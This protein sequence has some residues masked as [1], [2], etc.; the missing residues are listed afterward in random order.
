[1]KALNRNQYFL[2]IFRC[3][4]LR[5]VILCLLAALA[6]SGCMRRSAPVAVVQPQTDLDTMAYGQSLAA[7]CTPVPVA[8]AARRCR[9]R[10]D[11]VLPARCRRQAARRGLRPGRPHQYLRDR[12]RRLD[13]HAAD[14]LGAG[15]RPHAGGPGRRHHRQ[16]AQRL[17]PRALGG[18]RDRGLPAVL[19]PRR[20]CGA[21]PISLRAEHDASKA[22]SRSP[23]ASRRAPGATASRS[24]TPTRP[25]PVRVVVP[26]GTAIS[27]GDTVLVGE[28]WF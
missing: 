22:P 9:W 16:A 2:W 7:P 12:C 24:P 23:A 17:Y 25:A 8:Y 10:Y 1:M 3:E 5:A 18:G 4:A 26:L 20:G 15:A 21:R 6:L 28:R 13:H 14:R 11:T 27:P 19:H